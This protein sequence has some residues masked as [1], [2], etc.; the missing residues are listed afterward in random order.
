MSK[1]ETKITK[2]ELMKVQSMMSTFNQLKIKL[3]DAELTKQ[4]IFLQVE[5]LK[6]DYAEVE[7]ALTKKYGKDNLINLETG[8]VSSKEKKKE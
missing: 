7:A 5:D 6:K 8:I 3:G 2:D 4:Q 1:K